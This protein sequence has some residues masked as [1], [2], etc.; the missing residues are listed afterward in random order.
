[1]EDL[2][3]TSNM[4]KNNSNLLPIFHCFWDTADYWSNFCCWQEG[5]SILNTRPEW[6][7]K[8]WTATFVLKKLET[9][10]YR[11]LQTDGRTDRFYNSKCRTS[12]RSAAKKL[13][14][15][16]FMDR[17]SNRISTREYAVHTEVAVSREMSEGTSQGRGNVLYLSTGATCWQQCSVR[18]GQV[19][20]TVR[21]D[22]QHWQTHRHTHTHTRLLVRLSVCYTHHTTAMLCTITADAPAPYTYREYLM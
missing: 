16:L 13:A 1:M 19:Q 14:H 17:V 4:W 21:T 9:S 2:Y 15:D 18:E 7:P 5:G 10:I 6:T 22:I 11:K 20:W 3:A 12:L 8:F